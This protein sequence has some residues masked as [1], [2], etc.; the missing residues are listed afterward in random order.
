MN[1]ASEKTYEINEKEF[2][3]LTFPALD[4]LGFV[5]AAFSL[6]KKA[7]G[8]DVKLYMREGE[9]LKNVA[10]SN[11]TFLRQM[12]EK[13]PKSAGDISEEITEKNLITAF[14][15]HTANVHVIRRENLERNLST[16][17]DLMR[18]NIPETDGMITDVPGA[19]LVVNVADCA[20]VFLADPVNRAIGLCHSG[21]KGTLT[22][23][24]AEAVRKMAEEYG[25]EAGS[26]IACIAPCI[27]A[28][29]CEV[30]EEILA[31]TVRTWGEDA[32]GKIVRR[33][34]DGRLHFDL[35]EAN[36]MVLEKAGL[37]RDN[38]HVTG[39][40]TCC[41]PD[42]FYSYRGDGKIVNEMGAYFAVK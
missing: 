20:V 28:D 17:G 6:R 16:G 34:D 10:E 8:S 36:I 22:E 13:E 18:E 1:E 30:G 39:L 37:K 27:C 25:S 7:D 14:Q 42:M 41:R 40:C 12:Y 4:R 35:T 33:S 21:R 9:N 19:V 5:K 38:I 26:I 3:Y 32:A 29:C 15:K 24:G 23:I 11:R 31:E 2:P